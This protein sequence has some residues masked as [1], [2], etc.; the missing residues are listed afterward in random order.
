MRQQAVPRIHPQPQNLLRRLRRDLLDIDA[1]RGTHHKHRALGCPIHDESDVGLT[2]DVGGGDDK[3]PLHHQ[4]LDGHP[5]DS[6][7][8]FRR[9]GGGLGELHTACLAAPAGVHLGLHDDRPPHPPGDGLRLRRRGRHIAVRHRNASRAE[10][11]PALVF[12][13]IHPV[14]AGGGEPSSARLQ[15]RG[16]NAARKV[17]ADLSES[18]IVT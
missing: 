2:G 14:L 1:S 15:E 9:F 12:V 18:K 4:S 17:S 7:S 10:Q 13:E 16:P 6:L 3:H 5:Q 8:R 11:N